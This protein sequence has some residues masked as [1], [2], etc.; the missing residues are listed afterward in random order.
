VIRG[1]LGCPCGPLRP[2]VTPGQPREGGL[3]YPG[4]ISMQHAV[5]GGGPR[6]PPIYSPMGRGSGISLSS[7]LSPPSEHT[8]SCNHD[9]FTGKP[10]SSSSA[11]N[12][13]VR[14]RNLLRFLPGKKSFTRQVS[15]RGRKRTSPGRRWR[16]SPG[17]FLWASTRVGGWPEPGLSIPYR[18]SSWVGGPSST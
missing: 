5:N 15:S 13:A 18:P 7:R 16:W 2:G 6:P 3:G 12:S 1:G 17:P 11:Q 8:A 9:V 4:A 10:R 14:H